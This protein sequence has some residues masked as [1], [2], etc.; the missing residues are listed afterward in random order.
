MHLSVARGKAVMRSTD[1]LKRKSG[2]LNQ[3]SQHRRIKCLV[4][5]SYWSVAIPHNEDA[6]NFTC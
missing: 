2:V 3:M 1:L 6:G 4:A 5:D